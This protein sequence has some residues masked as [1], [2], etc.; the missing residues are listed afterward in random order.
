[1]V[2][3]KTLSDSS[4]KTLKLCQTYKNVTIDSQNIRLKFV[5]GCKLLT[6]KLTRDSDH[7][8]S[9]PTVSAISY[10]HHNKFTESNELNL[11]KKLETWI[12]IL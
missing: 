8:I 1:M 5:I 2:F 9:A 7:I 11:I 6:E 4:G 3:N 10:S 12:F